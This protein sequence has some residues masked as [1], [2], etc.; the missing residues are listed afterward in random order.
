MP[1]G[2]IPRL[3]RK[4]LPAGSR[5]PVCARCAL[6][7][8]TV[9]APIGR[10][11]REVILDALLADV[12]GVP[13]AANLAR[14]VT[15]GAFCGLALHQPDYLADDADR[16]PLWWIGDREDA[17]RR[18]KAPFSGPGAL[19]GRLE[20]D[21]TYGE[22]LRCREILRDLHRGSVPVLKQYAETAGVDVLNL[23]PQQREDLETACSRGILVGHHHRDGPRFAWLSRQQLGQSLAWLAYERD[24]GEIG[25]PM[26]LPTLTR[27]LV[28]ISRM[29]GNAPWQ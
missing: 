3:T 2:R 24:H 15:G 13:V 18:A 27:G 23:T 22:D 4:V 5:V 19:G 10:E 17:R 28:R 25:D 16:V 9:P 21:L 26:K 7:W 12:L 11:H 8:A 20:F 6:L 29:R 14:A 1:H